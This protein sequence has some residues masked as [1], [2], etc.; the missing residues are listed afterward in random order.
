MQIEYRRPHDIAY[1]WLDILALQIN[2]AKY[3]KSAW[4]SRFLSAFINIA[5]TNMRIHKESVRKTPERL[6]PTKSYSYINIAKFKRSRSYGHLR[7]AWKEGLVYA[8]IPHKS[9]TMKRHQFCKY[10]APYKCIGDTIQAHSVF[11]PVLLS[12]HMKRFSN[13][14]VLELIRC[15]RWFETL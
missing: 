5:L 7:I 15:K 3:Q 2:P 8:K 11:L 12:T 1:R 13:V 10:C 4:E 6:S 9:V 14:Q